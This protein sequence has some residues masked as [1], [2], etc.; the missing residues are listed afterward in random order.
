MNAKQ[1]QWIKRVQQEY[2]AEFKEKLI[3]DFYVMKGSPF[4][5]PADIR[6]LNNVVSPISSVSKIHKIVDNLCIKYDVLLSDIVSLK[7]K[8]AE[9][10]EWMDKYKA[11]MIDLSKNVME[12]RMHQTITAKYINKNRTTFSYHYYDKP[13]EP[14]QTAHQDDSGIDNPD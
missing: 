3:V 7:I 11:F 9:K 4:M 14:T 5:R 2:E 8:P 12:K 6:K 13:V 1:L 10:S